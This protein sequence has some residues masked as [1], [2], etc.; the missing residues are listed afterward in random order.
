VLK[1]KISNSVISGIWESKIELKVYFHF[2]IRMYTPD[3]QG[4]SLK[5]NPKTL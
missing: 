4:N 2:C 1:T 5:L 3:L